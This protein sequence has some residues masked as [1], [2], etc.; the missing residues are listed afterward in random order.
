MNFDWSDFTQGMIVGLLIL[1]VGMSGVLWTRRSK[2]R[3]HRDS[4]SERVDDEREHR[5]HH[6][7]SDR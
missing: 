3:R 4:V 7:D 5:H 1:F 2:K 6:R